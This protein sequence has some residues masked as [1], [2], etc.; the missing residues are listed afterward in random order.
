MLSFAG[1]TASVG[2]L[3]KIVERIGPLIKKSRDRELKQEVSKLIDEIISLKARLSSM[4]S[5]AQGVETELA[6]LKANQQAEGPAIS[7]AHGPSMFD[8]AIKGKL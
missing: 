1:I 8:D 6:K 7:I 4:V 2:A 3:D 5:E